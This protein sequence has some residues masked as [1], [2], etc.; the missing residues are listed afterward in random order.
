MVERMSAGLRALGVVAIVAA[1]FWIYWPALHGD[2][3][4]DDDLEVFANPALRS[5]RG[6]GQLWLGRAGPDYYPLKSTVQWAQWHLWADGLTGYHVTNV[7]LH[8][9]GALLFWRLLEN[10]GVRGAWLGGAIFAVHP[11]AVESV[12]WIAELK[13]CLSLPLLLLALNAYVGFRQTGRRADYALALGAF[14][15]AVLCKISVAGAPVVLLL[16]EWWRG[17]PVRGRAGWRLAPFFA[18]A[19]GFGALGIYFQHTRAVAG[20]ELD[21]GP[22][23][24]RCAAA[25]LALAF[26]AGKAVLPLRLAFLY[27]KWP[28][29][30][31]TAV[32]FLPWLGFAALGAWA[33]RRRAGW[34]RPVLFAL[35]GFFC[36]L[37]PAVGLV[38]IAYLRYS[39]VADHLA[40]LALLPVAGL[41][42]AAASTISLRPLTAGAAALA[43]IALGWQS[44]QYAGFFRDDETL[45]TQT[46]R[47]NPAAWAAHNNLGLA[48][49]ARGR[50]AAAVAHYEQAVQLKPD[51]AEAWDNLANTLA[52]TDRIP[53]A[54]ADYEKALRF[55]PAAPEMHSNYANALS[56]AGR[57]ADAIAEYE[58]ALRLKPD[59]PAAFYNLGVAWA[60]SGQNDRAIAAFTA[61]LRLEPN[62]PDAQNNLAA[63]LSA[64]G[65]YEDAIRCY[66]EALR[67]RSNFPEAENG[68]GLALAKSGHVA[69]AIPHF[70]AALRLRPD[71]ESARHNL[72]LAQ[73]A[74]GE[75]PDRRR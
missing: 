72:A 34:G 26:Y 18:I 32:Q 56:R 9:L 30:P 5:A 59:Y 67:L 20:W 2:R 54:I 41:A 43:L 15:A 49:E 75:L 50:F 69:E 12:A 10:L 48:L 47:T 17:N 70:E 51:Y 63:V 25:G 73:R 28:V 6:L 11:L 24:A 45:L 44:R 39:W 57:T 1:G 58:T 74:A 40:Y 21:A 7:L 37:L 65:R 23:I 35:G 4:M 60:D 53:E 62:L 55:A 66:R 3:L 71:F 46:L 14:T 68:L 8:V 64:A 13:N 61:A 19:L 16:Y 22:L 31:P 52:A 33:W 42:A 27:P 36:A 29:N 38:P